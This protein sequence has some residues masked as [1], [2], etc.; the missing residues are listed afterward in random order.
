MAT[1]RVDEN[2]SQKI[3]NDLRNYCHLDTLAMLEIF[4]LLKAL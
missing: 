1:R 3:Y 4:N 2:E